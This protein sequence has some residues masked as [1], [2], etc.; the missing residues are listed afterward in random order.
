MIKWFSIHNYVIFRLFIIRGQ[1]P[2]AH[3]GWGT[4]VTIMYIRTYRETG[5]LLLWLVELQT[6][7]S[8]DFTIK[9]KARLKTPKNTFTFKTLLRHYADQRTEMDVKLGWMETCR[10]L[11]SDCEIF[12]NLRLRL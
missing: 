10:G 3:R 6:K 4:S 5:T 9:E 1:Q 8:E 2:R 11:L 12:V 7:V